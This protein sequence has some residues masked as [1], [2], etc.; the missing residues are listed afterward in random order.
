MVEMANGLGPFKSKVNYANLNQWWLNESHSLSMKADTLFIDMME[1]G[2]YSRMKSLKKL[3]MSA[4]IS[5]YVQHI[6]KTLLE[7]L[8]KEEEYRNRSLYLHGT[9]YTTKFL[10]GLYRAMK[11]K[12]Y[13]IKGIS[14]SSP[15]FSPYYNM[16]GSFL[17]A[18]NNNLLEKSVYVEHQQNIDFLPV[19]SKAA[20]GGAKVTIKNLLAVLYGVKKIYKPINRLNIMGTCIAYHKA[21]LKAEYPRTIFFNNPRFQLVSMITKTKLEV[22]DL[23]FSKDPY[24]NP[25]FYQDITDQ[26]AKLLEE[27]VK[28][29]FTSGDH[30]MLSTWY[31]TIEA[32][33]NMNWSHNA[34]FRNENPR[35]L[36][37]GY[38]KG[39]ENLGFVKFDDAGYVISDTHAKQLVDAIYEN[40]LDLKPT[41]KEEKSDLAEVSTEI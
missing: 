29:L 4:K 12:G 9:G 25:L 21:C 5:V 20:H 18:I 30:D 33:T 8:G 23:E 26:Y 1:K 32:L 6:E 35:K 31:G 27:G 19:V 37:Y 16:K 22:I 24:N 39:A 17:L 2:G 13:T 11:S 38:A 40:L 41:Q 10:P 14:A 34:L 3:T 15:M 7:E 36:E 28:V